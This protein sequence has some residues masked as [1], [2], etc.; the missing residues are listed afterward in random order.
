MTAP[1]ENPAVVTIRAP[2]DVLALVPVLLGFVP[3]DS[4][5]MLTF[6]VPRPFHARVDLPPS[7]DLAKSLGELVSRLLAPVR[8]HG[9]PKVLFVLY[10]GDA[11]LAALATERLRTAF[12]AAAVDVV[13][14]I[15]TDGRRWW[16]AARDRPGFPEAGVPYDAG[17]H[18]LTAE[19]VLAGTAVLAS[20]EH[21]ARTVAYDP[22]L[23]GGVVAALAR[24]PD[25]GSAWS[26]AA[27]VAA[28][29]RDELRSYADGAR[30][31]DP[32]SVAWLLRALL[33]PG[34]RDAAADLVTRES[35]RDHVGFWTE[36]VRRTPDPL[37]AAPAAL[38]AFAAW[39]AGDGARAWCAVDRCLDAAPA[40]P[41]GRLVATVLEHAVPPDAWEEC[42]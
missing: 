25:V 10:T 18:P 31:P 35:A 27:E 33:E 11:R 9:V 23:A 17:S 7:P 13:E 20:R 16:P 14:A 8:M 5:V 37:V 34:S 6:G 39:R 30:A 1:A 29:V 26:P 21:L 28:R 3:A 12:R 15:R 24:P 40:D 22:E 42:E 2:E 19:A 38:L 36:V 32:D 4:V 41:L